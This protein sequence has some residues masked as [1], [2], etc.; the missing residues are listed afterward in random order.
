M[1]L[2][3]EVL[4]VFSDIVGEGN[5]A[6]EDVILDTYTFNCLVDLCP[7][8]A[9]GKYLPHRPAAVLLPGSTEEVQAIV[10]TCNFYKVKFK[11]HST[12]YGGHSLP[13]QE[14]VVVLDLMRMN[15]ILEIDEKNRYALVEPGCT[16]GQ[17]TAEAIKSG[18]MTT[19]IQAGFQTS[20]LANV[21]SGWGMNIFGVRGGYNGRNALGVEW[22]LPT[23]ELLKL[24][25]P[26]E[27]FT[28]DGPGPSLRGIMRGYVGALGGLGVFTKAAIK[29]HHWPGPS[30]LPTEPRGTIIVYK[31][32]EPPARMKTC[33][34]D[35]PDYESLANFMYAIGDAEI[36]YA[37]VRIGGV[38]HTL[39]LLSGGLAHQTLVDWHESGLIAAAAEEIRHPC[40]VVLFGNSEQEFVYQQ[41]VLEEIVEEA[42]GR[43]PPL[44]NESPFR[45]LL[46]EEFPVIILGND[47]H[48]AH[49]TGGFVINSGYGGTCDSV[50]RIQGLPAEELKEKYENR[51]GLVKSGR[52]TTYYN[53]FEHNSYI[54]I[55]MHC[56]YDSA[57]PF[58][59]QKARE[60][61]AEERESRQSE[62]C[63]Y[64]VNDICLG[65][66]GDARKSS[67]ERFAELGPLYGNFHIWQERIK[68]AFD[69][70]DVADRSNYGIGLFGKNIHV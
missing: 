8:P 22:V 52:D 24:G 64:Q 28:G 6:R 70:N 37:F 44:A 33:L 31:A 55:E 19:Q 34:V 5:I 69:P 14:G 4:K 60:L 30:S 66:A 29:L 45:E 32:K 68:R 15:R 67:Q 41:R 61:I 39:N 25:P 13:W 62:K 11:A 7:G 1:E 17:L 46:N 18:L 48:W 21:T 20:A 26:D 10:K 51:G 42:G 12:G 53:S 35:L 23:G 58:S 50:V 63:G 27:W 9:P 47:V 56:L 54:Y 2:R 49:H 16:W 59:V 3:P 57:D 65:A 43:I 36:A 40:V 38:E